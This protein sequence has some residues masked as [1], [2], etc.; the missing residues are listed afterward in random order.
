MGGRSP[1]LLSPT[2]FEKSAR[3]TTR[4]QEKLGKEDASTSS[5]YSCLSSVPSAS[6]TYLAIACMVIFCPTM[7]IYMWYAHRYLDG[8]IIQLRNHI[9]QEK[10]LL[11]IVDIWPVPTFF[12][13]MAVG[14]LAVSQALMQIL[15]PGAYFFGP[16]TPRGNRPLYKKNGFAAYWITMLTTWITW[17]EG[18]FN[19]ATIYDH[20]G[21]II[22][23]SICVSVVLC[24]LLYVKGY[25]A[26]SSSDCRSSGSIILDIFW[27]MELHPKIG[28]WLD[29]RELLTSRIAMT[30]WALL[31]VS[32]M[33]KQIET[34]G[35]LHDSMVVTGSLMLMYV[36]KH[37]WLEHSYL[38]SLDMAHDRTGLYTVWCSLVWVPSVYTS[39]ALFLASHPIELGLKVSV[40]IFVLGFISICILYDCDN[41]KAKFREANGRCHI[42]GKPATKII[43]HYLIENGE[44]HIS[45]L[46]TSGWWGLARNFHY[47]PELCSAFLWT[48]PCLFTH[49]LPYYYFLGL[50][51][52]L[53]DRAKRDDHRCRRKYQRYWEVYCRKVPWKIIPHVY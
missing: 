19:P 7:V 40:T 22:S 1:R 52:L 13:C 24:I 27:G 8:S 33:C 44:H 34:F 32:Y 12:G 9:R 17:R 15:L 14:A 39:P 41:Q 53:F 36:T 48:L 11:R 5:G 30:S 16:V 2:R 26:P 49:F 42:W 50:S 46:L 37:F 45:P 31:V 28:R 43:A 25:L 35:H 51:F 29:M 38:S 20:L 3:V 6:V 4:S 18:F 47:L 21:E 10:S 23:T